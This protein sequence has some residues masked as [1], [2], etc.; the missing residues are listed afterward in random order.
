MARSRQYPVETITDADYV[1]DLALLANTPTQEESLLHNLDQTA[2]RIGLHGKAN[3]T[4]YICFKQGAIST[5][6]G[7]P[8]KLVDKFTYLGRNISSTESWYIPSEGV[9]CYW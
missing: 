6:N 4:E 7:W 3:K 2:G 5:L 1:D 9:D 8:L